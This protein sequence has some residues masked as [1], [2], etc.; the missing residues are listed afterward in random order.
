MMACALP[1]QEAH[2]RKGIV[3]LTHYH[4]LTYFWLC[5][6][7]SSL[8]IVWPWQVLTT[9]GFSRSPWAV[10]LDEC[11]ARG[12]FFF[13]LPLCSQRWCNS[14]MKCLDFSL[15]SLLA[16]EFPAWK[17]ASFDD[18]GILLLGLNS[19]WQFRMIKMSGEHLEGKQCL[20]SHCCPILEWTSVS[21]GPLSL[22]LSNFISFMEVLPGENTALQKMWR[23]ELSLLVSEAWRAITFHLQKCPECGIYWTQVT[24][25]TGPHVL[26]KY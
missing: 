19:L 10:L 6:G 11:N 26:K 1:F 12:F 15:G 21:P 25:R 24:Q 14:L 23:D 17:M 8:W 3:N 22:S 7:P 18:M 13:F 9:L 16:Y 2:A 5:A 4:E 20:M